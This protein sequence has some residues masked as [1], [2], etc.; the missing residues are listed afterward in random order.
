[1]GERVAS[2][3]VANHDLFAA[4]RAP[5]CPMCRVLA[6]SDQRAVAS[7]VFEGNRDPRVRQAF[8]DACG[9]CPHHAVAL[10]DE[11]ERIGSGA[12][13]ADLYGKVADRD[14]SSLVRSESP[15]RRGRGADPTPF[16][17][18]P[19]RCYL[20]AGQAAA[21]R[22][23][24]HF[25]LNLLADAAA[26]NHYRDSEGLCR[27]HV[28]LVVALARSSRKTAELGEWLLDEWRERLLRLRRTLADYDRK[29]DYRFA[30]QRTAAEQASWRRIIRLYAERPI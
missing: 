1:M 11:S 15:R 8:L 25:L 18:E 30:D 28:R 24:A 14:L 12:V 23:Q 13:I 21:E 3:D 26:K 27:R 2:V 19:G 5:G 17:C 10:L 22:R 4:L 7:F 9:F 20:C 6:D 29:R 16:L